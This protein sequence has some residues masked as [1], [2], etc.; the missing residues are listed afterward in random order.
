MTTVTMAVTVAVTMTVVM[1]ALAVPARLDT[2]CATPHACDK[3]P[4]TR[5]AMPGIAGLKRK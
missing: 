2:L 5:A 4:L 3:A 1:T